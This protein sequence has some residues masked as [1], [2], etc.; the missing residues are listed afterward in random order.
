MNN[1]SN[2]KSAVFNA[3]VAGNLLLT[4]LLL[5]FLNFISCGYSRNFSPA[6]P[7]WKDADDK[8]IADPGTRDPLLEWETADRTVFDQTEQFFDLPRSYGKISGNR[9]QALNINSYDEVPNS[10][11][12]TNRHFLF[13]MTVEEIKQGVAQTPGPDT[14]GSWIIW[15]PKVQGVTPGLFIKDKNGDRFILKFDPPGHPDMATSAAA[16]TSR[17]FHAMG[18]NVPQETIIYWRPDILKIKEGLMFEDHSGVRR[19]FTEDDLNKVLKRVH[20]EEDGTIRSLAS[21]FLPNVR[22]PF[23]FDGRRTNDPNDWCPH[24]HRRELRGL[25]VFCSF[26]NHWDIKDQNTMDILAEENDRK[27]LKHCLL[28][29]G[30]DRKSVV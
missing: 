16:I 4:L 28:D 19:L 29:F 10:S 17:F 27:F 14:S 18:Y 20:Y 15:K 2:I 7:H 6:E 9:K 13:P 8:D 22:G 30:S 11:W 23:S 12:Y 5:V 25:Y 26:V 24:E 3:R 1:R 21:K